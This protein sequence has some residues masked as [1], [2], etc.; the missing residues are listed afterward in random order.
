[1]AKIWKY[2]AIVSAV[3]LLLG[4]VCL[5]VG[6]M[7]GASTLRITAKLVNAFH[8]DQIAEQIKTALQGSG[9]AFPLI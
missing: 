4:V 1:M 7:N 8:I 9:I 5:A 2:V 6:F 3:L